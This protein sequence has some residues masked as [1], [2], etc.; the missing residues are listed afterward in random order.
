MVTSP[1]LS[2]NAFPN[3]PVEWSDEEEHRRKLAESVNNIL[4]G[5]INSIGSVTFTANQTTTTITDEKI[6][7]NSLIFLTP[8]TANAGGEVGYYIS[9]VGDGSA[10][11][12]HANDARNDR[13]FNYL[14]AG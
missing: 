10:T 5:K 12:T 3:V 13:T 4:D 8:V 14:I 7:S 6:G 11:I 9:A 1:R 2:S